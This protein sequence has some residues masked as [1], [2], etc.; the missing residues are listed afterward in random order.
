MELIDADGR[1]FGII[2]II[3]GF[4]VFVVFAAAIG[5]ATFFLSDHGGSQQESTEVTVRVQDVEP[6]VADAIRKGAV[7][8]DSVVA[9]E[10]KTVHPTKVAVKSQNGTL[11]EQEHPLKR[12]V[13]LRMTLTVTEREDE[14]RFRGEPLEVG[15]ELEIDLGDVTIRCVVTSIDR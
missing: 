4:V 11:R 13:V 6:F 7:G 10:N 8:A 15:R 1:I 5:G 2:N 12:T 14:V 9:V 3:D